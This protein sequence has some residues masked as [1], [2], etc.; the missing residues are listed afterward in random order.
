M[1]VDRQA[2]ALERIAGLGVELLSRDRQ[3]AAEQ[4]PRRRELRRLSI[5]AMMHGM[6]ALAA[7]FQTVVP[8]EF[9]A[10]T[11]ENEVTIACPCGEEPVIH[12]A[13]PT[14]CGCDRF[15][16]YTGD[17]VRVA[18]Y[19]GWKDEPDPEADT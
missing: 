17:S 1:S 5:E 3:R 18:R 12:R 9:W 8:P 13:S 11:G 4:R 15:F 16:L 19:P 10:L 6:P 2:D 7:Q 14:E